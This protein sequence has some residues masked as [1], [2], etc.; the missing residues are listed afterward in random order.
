MKKALVIFRREYAAM[1]RTKAFVVSVIAMP[2]L[3][4]GIVALQVAMEHRGATTLRRVAVFD[5]TG[6]LFEEL[7]RLLEESPAGAQ[8]IELALEGRKAPDPETLAQTADA[9]RR[10]LF[11]AVLVLEGGLLNPSATGKAS[12]Y[13]ENVAFSKELRVLREAVRQA[14]LE[15]RLEALELDPKS[16]LWAAEQVAL[17]ASGLPTRD[18][19]GVTVVPGAVSSV[20]ASMMPLGALMLMFLSIMVAAQPMLQSVIEEKQLRIAE[21]LL[22]SARQSEIMWGKLLGNLAVA[23]TMTGVYL[24]GGLVAAAAFVA[25]QVV[26]IGFLAW[27]LVFEL[28]AAA[29]YGSVFLAI[30]AACNELRDTQSLLAPVMIV[31]VLPLMLWPHLASEPTGSLATALS[32]F[33]LTAPLITVARLAASEAIPAWQPILSA[34]ITAMTTAVA[35]AG[36]ANVFK[37]GILRQG[38]PMGAAGLIKAALGK[39]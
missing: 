34:L 4:A 11:S 22:G 7:R 28:L 9:V 30:G 18:D 6:E 23:F 1:V 10:G 35:V 31:L 8:N 38:N 17:E 3:M 33:P 25:A 19:A 26:S 37:A 29:M 13:T 24:L 21:V 15:A 27:F 36:A 16:R 5:G 12:F 32:F 39:S 20:L 2:L 14:V